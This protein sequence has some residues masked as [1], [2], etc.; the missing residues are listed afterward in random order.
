MCMKRINIV[1]DEK[2]VDEGMRLTGI[3]TQRG[4]IDHALRELIRKKG[5]RKMLKMKGKIQWEGNLDKMRESRF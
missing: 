5:Q 2:L 1:L 3:K 4:L